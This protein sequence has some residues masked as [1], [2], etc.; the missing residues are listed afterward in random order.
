MLKYLIYDSDRASYESQAF[1]TD[2]EMFW[3]RFGHG[4]NL[5]HRANILLNYGVEQ[6]H[7]DF[8]SAALAT[9]N[10]VLQQGGSISEIARWSK[11]WLNENGK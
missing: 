8:V 9:Y 2:L 6:K 4:Y 1:G 3:W 10:D 11:K 5:Q 7:C